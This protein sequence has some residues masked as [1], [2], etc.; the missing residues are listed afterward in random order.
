MAGGPGFRVFCEAGDV[1]SSHKTTRVNHSL[2]SCRE[3][4]SADPGVA[5]IT[6]CCYH[7]HVLLGTERARKEFI[8][9]IERVRRWYGFYVT[10]YVVMPEHVHLLIS[11]PERG[12]LALSLQMLKQVVSRKLGMHPKEPF[13]Q[14][15]YYDFN[16]WSER[17][18]TEKLRY[19]QSQSGE[20]WLSRIAGRM[21]VEQLSALRDGRI[22]RSGSR[23]AMDG[24]GA[25]R[26][27][28]LSNSAPS[29]LKSPA[30]AKNAKGWATRPILFV[31]RTRDRPR[32]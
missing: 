18:I 16:V 17:K 9:A 26:A 8:V 31:W 22:W 23:I 12:A 11:E 14:P 27:R 5:F 29:W 24:T 28:D 20:A 19:I 2:A 32:E 3:A 1:H 30:F 4:L 7:R 25:G 15:R 21:A 10:G 13:W 6:F